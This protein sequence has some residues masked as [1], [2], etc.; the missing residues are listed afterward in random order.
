MEITPLADIEKVLIYQEL[1]LVEHQEVEPAMEDKE[2]YHSQA[3]E[4][5]TAKQVPK[6]LL[7][8]DSPALK[9]EAPSL[10]ANQAQAQVQVQVQAQDYYL[11]LE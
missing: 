5:H 8:M 6:E 4:L 11:D 9:V 2:V 3:V 1:E 7:L 10:M